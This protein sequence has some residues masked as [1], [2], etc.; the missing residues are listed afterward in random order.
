M[1]PLTDPPSDMLRSAEHKR[2]AFASRR[3]CPDCGTDQVQIIAYYA[4]PPYEWRCR[5]CS[6]RWTVE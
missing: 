6:A 1:S 2:E 4:G 5:H 3:A